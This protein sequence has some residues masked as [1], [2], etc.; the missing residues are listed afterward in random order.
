M[1]FCTVSLQLQNF[2]Y[3]YIQNKKVLDDTKFLIYAPD[4]GM[5]NQRYEF[6]GAGKGISSNQIQ[7]VTSLAHVKSA[8]PWFQ[9]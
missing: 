5:E 1:A 3:D 2:H 8:K 9:K 6:Y 7:Q 4:L